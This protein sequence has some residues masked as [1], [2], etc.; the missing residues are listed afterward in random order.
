MGFVFSKSKL[1]TY[2]IIFES[3]KEI[4]DGEFRI[5]YFPEPIDSKIFLKKSN[6]N[7]NAIYSKLTKGHVYTIMV[8]HK[9]YEYGPDK[10]YLEDVKDPNVYEITRQI[11]DY[12]DIGKEFDEQFFELIFTR[13]HSKRIV[14]NL[15]QKNNL[16]FGNVYNIFFTKSEY[17]Y[18]YYVTELIP[19]DVMYG[20]IIPLSEQTYLQI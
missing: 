15:E 4:S 9:Y 19:V 16:I 20:D 3:I 17:G 18:L 8:T 6:V 12:I 11:F 5:R 7:F 10:M 14:V 13:K 1:Y 2:D